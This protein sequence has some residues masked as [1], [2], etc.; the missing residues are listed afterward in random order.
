MELDPTHFY[1]LQARAPYQRG[2]R[3]AQISQ[4]TIEL[5]TLRIHSGAVEA[6]DPFFDLGNGVRFQAPNGDHRAVVT[7]AD[8][9]GRQDGSHLRESYLSLLFSDAP[10]ARLALATPLL[11]PDEEE[12]TYSAWVGVETGTV[13]FTD[14][15]VL[16]FMPDVNHYDELFDSGQPDSWFALMDNPHHIARY[17][18]NIPLPLGQ[19]GENLVLSHSGWGDG[20]YPV[21]AT[22]AADGNLTGLHIDLL[23]V[24]D[25]AS[26]KLD[27]DDEEDD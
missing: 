24:N 2:S 18:A 27:V 4:S 7:V 10:T 6:C 16:Q 15:T 11:G 12:H 26:R 17:V 19:A 9:S 25:D 8:V 21:L 22:Y 1:A 13:A 3:E 23:V 5:G 20:V 14:R